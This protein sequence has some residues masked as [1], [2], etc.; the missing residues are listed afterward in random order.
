MI[1]AVILSAVTAYSEDV[2][3]IGVIYSLTGNNAVPA[4]LTQDG[5]KL[6]VKEINDAGGI[7]IDGKKFKIR[8]FY[9][10]AHSKPIVAAKCVAEMVDKEG[11][12]I[13]IGG[14]LAHIGM[15]LNQQAKKHELFYMGT[16]TLPQ[17]FF[18]KGN[19]APAAVSALGSASAIGRSTAEYL[20]EKIKPKRVACFMPGYAFGEALHAG[21]MSVIKKY[22]DIKTKVFWHPLGSSDMK[23][24]LFP[25]TQFNPDVLAIGSFGKDGVNALK[26]SSEL[27][28][29]KS[30][31]IFHMWLA[32]AFAAAVPPETMANV[33]AQMFWYHDMSGFKDE[34]VI[35]ASSQFTKKYTEAF[36]RPPDPYAMAAYTGVREIVRAME[37]SKSTDPIK[38]YDALMSNPE[39]IGPK[40]KAVWRKDGRP[41][42]KTFSLIVKGKGSDKRTGKLSDKKYEFAEVVDVYSGRAFAPELKDLGY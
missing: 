14:I 3:K 17:A 25:V 16:L 2:V 4:K 31:K 19:K 41:I 1:T 8:P 7:K 6:A 32:D 42:Y 22:P 28:I 36:G 20:G 9:C 38:M 5:V 26:Q 11:I 10:D 33:S 21:F 34:A 40:G 35:K 39:W 23:R 37:L 13:I 18:E 15:A 29:G 27:G 12:K 24:D 30:A